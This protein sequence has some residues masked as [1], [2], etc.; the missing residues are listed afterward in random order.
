MID[1]HTHSTHSD[2]TL[3][4]DKLI[5]YACNQGLSAIALTDHDCI[6]G[7]PIAKKQAE[8]RG[9]RFFPGVELEIESVQGSFH[10]LGLNIHKNDAVLA[11]RLEE[12]QK[13]RKTRNREIIKKMQ[14]AG[15]DVSIEDIAS[16]AGGE[17]IS[18][19][20][21]AL[22]LINRKKA[23]SVK[24]AFL[25][26]LSPGGTF[27]IPKEAMTLSE[28]VQMIHAAGG[29]AV[30]AHPFSLKMNFKNLCNFISGCKESG[31]DGIEA[32]HSEYGFTLC[33]RLEQFAADNGLIVTAGSDF[34]G[35]GIKNRKLGKTAGQTPIDDRFLDGLLS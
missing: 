15:I 14:D 8:K 5:D 31:L 22:Y 2:G 32:Y 35:E 29:K 34:H 24:D 33:S 10:L 9:I 26:F 17:V 6:S 21:F 16:L 28:A 25:R 11:A 12:V 27:F 20:H 3:S 18:R 7:N 13:K 1:L 4:P 23:R 19:L 30:I